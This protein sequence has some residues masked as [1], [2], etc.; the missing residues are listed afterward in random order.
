VECEPDD[1]GTNVVLV[2][3]LAT[4]VLSRV[5][6]RDLKPCSLDHFDN[7]NEALE[8]AALDNFEYVVERILQHR[9]CGKRKQ[10]GKRARPK[11][12]Y[13]FEVLW[14]NLPLEEGENPSWEPWSN[15]SLRSC[16]P[17]KQYCRQPEVLSELG[18]DFGDGDEEMEPKAGKGKRRRR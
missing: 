18:A 2:Q 7:I 4:K 12:N 1:E 5:H 11:G 15:S 14:A 17:F 13:E 3:H 6:A 8:I 9:P 16:E 10:P